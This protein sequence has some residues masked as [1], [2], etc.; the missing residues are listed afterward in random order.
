MISKPVI[1]L[2]RSLEHKKFRQQHGM[3]IAEGRKIIS[4][5]ISTGCFEIEELFLLPESVAFIPAELLKNIEVTEISYK[6]LER[7]SQHTTPDFGLALV[8]IPAE[9]HPG[10]PDENQIF[11]LLDA[12][13][14]PG[15]LGTI[16]R[17]CDWLGISQIIC[18]GDTVDVY[19]PKV[20]QATM[21]SLCRVN[22]SY[23]DHLQWLKTLPNNVSVYG[24]VLNGTPL[25]NISPSK[26]SV[27]VMGNES[28]GISDDVLKYVTQ[29]ITIEKSPV[30]TAESLNAAIATGIVL[31]EFSKVL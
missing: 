21:G 29:K 16:I 12:I 10:F 4:E 17:L 13:R 15:N 18:S 22:V 6:L 1:S 30:S 24:T 2:L 7:I 31:Y 28:H 11:L 25:H 19:S 20:I 23:T 26:P 14:D 9:Q 8:R 5:M 27:I 3:F